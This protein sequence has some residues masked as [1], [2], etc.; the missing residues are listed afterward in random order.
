MKKQVLHLA[1]GCAL[2]IAFT[3]TMGRATFGDPGDECHGRL[4]ADHARIDR[5][6]ARHGD[7]S[8]QVR[9]DVNRMEDDRHWCRDHHRD[10]DHSRFDVGIYVRH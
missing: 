7:D 1:M 9:R 3:L 6:A 5:D 10:W 4:E 8:W 2:A